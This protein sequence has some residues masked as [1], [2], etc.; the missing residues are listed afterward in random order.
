MAWFHDLFRRK[1]IGTPEALELLLRGNNVRSGVD[2][3][4]KTAVEVATVIG[5]AGV[6]AESVATVPL[7]I[8]RK[9]GDQ[10]QPAEDH[11]LSKLFAFAPNSFQDSLQFRET[12][13]WHVCLT[14]NAFVYVNRVRG[15]I[16]ELI[17]ITPDRVNVKQAENLVVTY[18]VTMPDN[19]LREF[20]QEEIWQIR[21]PSWCA[22]AG[23]SLVRRSRESIGLAIALERSHASFHKNAMRPSGVFVYD[24]PLNEDQF[25]QSRAMLAAQMAGVDN[26]GRPVLADRGLKFVSL[27][28]TGVDAQHLESRYFQ[29]EE[30]CRA[31]RVL[32]IMIGHADKTATY[33]SA[34]Q[35]FIAHA[36][37]TA[38]PW[39]RRFEA[40]INRSLIGEK[41]FGNG[42]YAKFIDTEMLRGSSKDRADYYK[43]AILT[44]WM[45]RNEARGFEEMNPLDGLDEPITPMNMVTGNPLSAD[46]SNG[47]S[48]PNNTNDNATGI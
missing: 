24:E 40:A 47:A 32:P 5:C 39:Q 10:R 2:V 19:R 16:M 1:S 48:Q 38:R 37:Y 33:A 14:G 44:G 35:M 45:T 27:S 20:S 17:P 11:P 23:D 26:T 7:K 15:K 34:E 22:Y 3:T 41:D 9:T 4:W 29:I 13:A 8:F 42:I 12:L 30:I 21:G 18:E 28:M 46:Q 36:S 31:F 43:S 25:K 6:I